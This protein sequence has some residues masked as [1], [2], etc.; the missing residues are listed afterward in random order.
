LITLLHTS[1]MG[2]LH[3]KPKIF[4]SGDREA[5]LLRRSGLMCRSLALVSWAGFLRTEG[6]CGSHVAVVHRM[7]K[8]N[9]SAKRFADMSLQK[10]LPTVYMHA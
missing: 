4:G 10:M 1:E 2:C 8:R 5:V 3:Q 7:R 9:K 6:S